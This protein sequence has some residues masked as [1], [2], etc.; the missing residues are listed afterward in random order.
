MCAECQWFDYHL[1][2]SRVVESVSGVLS[3]LPADRPLLLGLSG[4]ADSVAL[5]RSFLLIGRPFTAVHCDFHLRG[6]E[7]ERD[8]RFVERLCRRHDVVLDT[9]HFDAAD[10]CRSSG[11]S[12]EEGCRCLRYDY[13]REKIRKENYA[14]VR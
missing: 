3:A 9:V 5:F 14:R 1:M 6:E 12:L 13:F 10:Y 7:S 4:G 11:L 8:R 2:G